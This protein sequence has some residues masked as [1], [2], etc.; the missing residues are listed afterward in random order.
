M[1]ERYVM[2]VLV[3]RLL[4]EMKCMVLVPGIWTVPERVYE[5]GCVG[6]MPECVIAAASEFIEVGQLHGVPS[7]GACWRWPR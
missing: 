5:F 1:M 3:G 6:G 4:A 7:I 2:L